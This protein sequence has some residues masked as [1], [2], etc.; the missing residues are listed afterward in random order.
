[1]ALLL[2]SEMIRATT[3]SGGTIKTGFFLGFQ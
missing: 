2:Y 3:K 1:L